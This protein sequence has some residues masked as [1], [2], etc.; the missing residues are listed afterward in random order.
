[1]RKIPEQAHIWSF[2]H[3]FASP[4]ALS[5]EFSPVLSFCEVQLLG[6]RV[7]VPMPHK[8]LIVDDH[9]ATRRGLHEFLAKAGYVV[10]SASTFV[11]GK[12][13]LHE[14]APDLLIADVRL[15]DFN[16]LQLVVGGP[17]LPT[18]I[19]TGFPD[20]VLEAEALRLG[21]HFLTKPIAPQ[22]LLVL[23]EEKFI[24]AARRQSYGSKRRWDR[25]LV[26]AELSAHVDDAFAR[27]VDISYGGLRFE[28]ERQQPLPRSF[29]VTVADPS[30]SIAVD[31]VWETRS[32]DRRWVCGAAVSSGNVAAL[33]NWATLVDALPSAGSSVSA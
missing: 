12:R 11:E 18:I 28:M 26:S 15:G 31:L 24:S 13:L 25:K 1:M 19:V 16:G 9:D 2:A 17:T 33:H 8:I 4:T 29:S 23:I 7:I 21:A 27:I 6:S 32:G 20:P 10:L 14:Q 3:P 22:Q 5:E 30:L